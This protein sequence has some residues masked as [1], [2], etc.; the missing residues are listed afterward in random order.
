MSKH[1]ASD[2]CSSSLIHP[3]PKGTTD[4]SR[5]PRPAV[6]A[7]QLLRRFG[8]ETRSVAPPQPVRLD[9]SPGNGQTARRAWAE[10]AR[11]DAS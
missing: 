6:S 11:E 10:S 8:I 9:S 4:L 2:P 3:T 5:L 7:E 1:T